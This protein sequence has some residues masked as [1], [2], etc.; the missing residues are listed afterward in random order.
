MTRIIL[1]L[2]TI[3]LWS[4]QSTPAPKPPAKPNIV[5]ILTDDQGWGDLST[6]GNPHLQTPAM[7]QLKAGGISLEQFYVSP[8]CAPTRAS[9]LSGRYHLSTG[10]ISVSKGMERMRGEEVTIAELLKSAGYHTGCFGKWHNGLNYPENPQ[11][12]GFDQF[13]GFSAGHWN[14]YFD[15]Q[16]E[17]NSTFKSTEGYIS[18]VLTDAC[19]QFI[20]NHQAEPFFAFVPY[21]APH[22][23]FQVPDSYFDKFKDQ[24]LDDRLA[25]IYGMVENLDYNIARILKT[26]DDLQL[27]E[28]TLVIFATDNGPNGQR[29]NGGMKGWKGRVDQGGVRVPMFMRW[30]GQFPEGLQIKEMAAHID[31]LPTLADLLDLEMPENV[32][33][34]SLLPLLQQT[35]EQLPARN[36]YTH[37]NFM[38][39]LKPDPGAIRDGRYL[40]TVKQEGEELY[41]LQYDPG[42]QHD[43]APEETE[44]AEKLSQ[45]YHS[46]YQ[47]TTEG[48]PTL[49]PIP[50][51]IPHAGT[52]TLFPQEAMLS[53][54]LKYKEGHGWANDWIV[55]WTS[56]E[57][58]LTW[59]LNAQQ[60]VSY[61]VW[62]EYTLAPEETGSVIGAQVGDQSLSISLD[63]AFIPT[64]IPS[65][66]RVP[67]IE[68]YEQTWNRKLLGTIQLD[69]GQHR[70]V[71]KSEQVA[72]AEVAEFR[73]LF[74]TPQ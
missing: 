18:D 39:E 25:A 58:S 52:V 43:I 36:L 22:G 33:G 45:Q 41:D 69:P 70:L 12:Q 61:Q 67:R 53:D 27:S 57:D 71:L 47:S 16:L 51:G 19:I 40:L 28:N 65:P 1:F 26:L 6:H 46:W 49:P 2:G 13:V 50:I 31:L 68:M 54:S 34:I 73:G 21:N 74:L 55:N 9:F 56:T 4:C 17:F 8:L 20:E 30:S 11:G 44:I 35:Q 63:E 10:T 14:N 48:L 15:T 23:P 72:G 66:D 38:T 29:F 32:D 64:R 7:D 5:F 62:M 3:A 24:G 59:D 60:P 37:V 42:Q